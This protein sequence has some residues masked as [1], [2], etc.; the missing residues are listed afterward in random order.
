[1]SDDHRAAAEL[2]LRRAE[3]ELVH[4]DETRAAAEASIAQ[5][6]A[7]LAGLTTLDVYATLAGLTT[8]D[9]ADS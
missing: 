2:W 8:L 9:E 6:Y 1:M 3:W 5:A 7:T 4:G